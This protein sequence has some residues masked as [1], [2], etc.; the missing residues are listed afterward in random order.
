VCIQ[1]VQLLEGLVQVAVAGITLGMVWS[2][3]IIIE[4]TWQQVSKVCWSKL[5]VGARVKGHLQAE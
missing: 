3:F 4:S 2:L 1:E 5:V